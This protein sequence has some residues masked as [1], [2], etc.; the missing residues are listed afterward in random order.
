MARMDDEL[1]FGDVGPSFKE[2]CRSMFVH[3]TPDSCVL[4]WSSRMKM[5]WTEGLG[6]FTQVGNRL[7]EE[8]WD[9]RD[10]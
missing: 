8:N 10:W 2:P 5:S 4:Y 9:G 1:L 6:P 3:R 7:V